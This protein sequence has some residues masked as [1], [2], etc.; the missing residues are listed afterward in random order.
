MT[1][2]LRCRSAVVCPVGVL[3]PARSS[4]AFGLAEPPSSDPPACHAR[5]CACGLP[6]HSTSPP[7][8]FTRVLAYFCATPRATA[9]GVGVAFSTPQLIWLLGITAP[10]FPFRRPL[11]ACDRGSQE[12]T[13]RRRAR[14][15]RCRLRRAA[16]TPAVYSE[17]EGPAPQACRALPE[18]CD[19]LPS[20]PSS[21]SSRLREP[22]PP[23]PSSKK[24]TARASCAAAGD[25][26]SL[27]ELLPAASPAT[28][29]VAG[30]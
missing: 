22:G 14:R 1:A 13:V 11:R 16:P 25:T 30:R 26:S 4:R 15:E 5:R 6:A 8:S 29:G 19:A 2:E 17:P 20:H 24:L 18:R 27:P 12:P 21:P 23:S 7:V 10:G 28:T 9:D 3:G